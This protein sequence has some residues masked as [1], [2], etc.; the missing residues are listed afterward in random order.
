MN[1]R[2][3]IRQIFPLARWNQEASI[4]DHITKLILAGKILNTLHQILITPSIPRNKLPND[5]NRP[6]APALIHTI[7]QLILYLAEL[8]A[9]KKHL[10]ASRHERL[11]AK[12][13]VYL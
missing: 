11:P 10:R 5:R 7:K 13:L 3:T 2:N 6:K 1:C 8:Q 12:P 9:R 4:L